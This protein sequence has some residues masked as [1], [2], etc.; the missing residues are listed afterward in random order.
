V[1][2]VDLR[3]EESAHIL[4]DGIGDVESLGPA[5]ELTLVDA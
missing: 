4:A 2:L 5:D 1:E 3:L